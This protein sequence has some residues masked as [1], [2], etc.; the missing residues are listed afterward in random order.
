[1]TGSFDMPFVYSQVI[2]LIEFSLIGFDKTRHFEFSNSRRAKTVHFFLDDYKFDE[3]W[4]KPE[5]QTNRLLRYRQVL[6]PDFSI[7]TDM[8]KPLQIYNIFRNRWCASVWQAA[9]MVVIPTISWGA[10]DTFEFAFDGVETGSVVAVSTVGTNRNHDAFMLGFARMCQRI[11][12][13][14]VVVYGTKHQG[15]EDLANLIEL[16]YAHGSNTKDD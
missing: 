6:S 3:V 12:P 1:M 8:P 10:E 5:R 15:M 4:N 16:P 11:E 2:D 13:R 7:Y 14:A 9:K